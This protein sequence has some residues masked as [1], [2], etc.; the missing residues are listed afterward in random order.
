[1]PSLRAGHSDISALLPPDENR[2][3]NLIE[4]ES[5]Y[6]EACHCHRNESSFL[7]HSKVE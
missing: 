2:P 6:D 3:M 1:M 4:S 5:E 7:I